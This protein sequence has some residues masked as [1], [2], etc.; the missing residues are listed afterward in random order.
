MAPLVP[1]SAA[2]RA[3]SSAMKNDI[4][5]YRTTKIKGTGRHKRKVEAEYH[6][7]PESLVVAGTVAV[8]GVATAGAIA[9]IALF[10][11]GMGASRESG[12]SKIYV[13]KMNP[14]KAGSQIG[15]PPSWTV[16]NSRGIPVN[17]LTQWDGRGSSILSKAQ[18]AQGYQ[19]E[20]T[21]LV[22]NTEGKIYTV[23]IK[24]DSKNHFALSSRPR[25]G[26]SGG[27]I[28]PKLF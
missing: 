25:F 15:D 8:V 16:Y 17:R 19:A 26:S 21:R 14:V 20:D 6:V 2:L 5:I 7:N 4:A 23:K 24:N 10:A 3:S 22:D 11:A 13:L 18:I 28:I 1:I 12:I 9:A 27:S